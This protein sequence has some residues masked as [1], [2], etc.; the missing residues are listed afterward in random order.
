[1]WGLRIQGHLKIGTLLEKMEPNQKE[2][3]LSD[4]LW[5]QSVGFKTGKTVSDCLNSECREK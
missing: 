2:N 4:P 5:N 3:T 1:M